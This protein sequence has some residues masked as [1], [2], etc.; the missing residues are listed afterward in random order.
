MYQ[1]SAVYAFWNYVLGKANFNLGI[2][3]TNDKI[4]LQS[5]HSVD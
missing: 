1:K 4:D 3:M 2:R 5:S